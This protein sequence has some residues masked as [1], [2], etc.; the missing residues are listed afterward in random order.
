MRDT[1]PPLSLS[2]LGVEPL[3]EFI[4]EIADFVHHMIQTRPDFP[5]G[6]VEVEAKVGVLRDKATG[7]RIGPPV[8]VETI[9]AP[10]ENWRFESNMSANQH[11]HFNTLLNDLKTTSAQSS[12][13]AAPLGYKHLYLIDSF[14]TSDGGE[15]IRVTREEKTGVVTQCV[16][17][18]RLGNL[19]IYS[20]KR[21]ADWRI[22]VNL[23]VPVPHP[24]G[25][26]SHT[27]RKHRMSYSHEEFTIDLTQVTS[28]ISGAPPQILHELELEFARH[29][30]L[31]LTA[32]KRGDMNLPEHDRSA[33][34]ELIRAFVNNARILVRNSSEGWQ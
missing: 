10:D 18:I 26:V 33:F 28:N 7:H 12:H 32:A 13:P 16:R 15:K 30:L 23:E 24:V 22:S 5:G 9:L 27:R 11:R 21:A 19:N 8:L 4:K 31:L 20:P 1:L 3:D 2:I 17:K 29:E 6:S 34:D 25:A 14:Y